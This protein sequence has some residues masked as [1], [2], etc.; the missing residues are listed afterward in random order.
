MKWK[1]IFLLPSLKREQ[2]QA[3][4]NLC[5][6]NPLIYTEQGRHL[7]NRFLMRIYELPRPHNYIS[8]TL[9]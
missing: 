9:N 5:V 4:F 3:A 8:L 6:G 7:Y 1:E 2:F